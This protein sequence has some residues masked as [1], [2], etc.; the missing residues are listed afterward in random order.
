M[1]D[2]VLV[3]IRIA[4]ALD[5]F[6][7]SMV[8]IHALFATQQWLDHNTQPAIHSMM[9]WVGMRRINLNIRLER[10]LFLCRYDWCT[11]FSLVPLARDNNIPKPKGE[12]VVEL[13]WK[14]NEKTKKKQERITNKSRAKITNTNKLVH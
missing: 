1:I 11:F 6:Y 12:Y 4:W 14:T 9:P 2:F 5:H 7:C 8:Q 3:C 13:K 10:D